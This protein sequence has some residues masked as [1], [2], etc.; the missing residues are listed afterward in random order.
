[1]TDPSPTSQPTRRDLLAGAAASTLL[2]LHAEAEA[3]P[4]LPQNPLQAQVDALRARWAQGTEDLQGTLMLNRESE[5]GSAGQT[6]A[7]RRGFA[8]IEIFK[9]I[10]RLPVEAQAQRP[11][12]GLFAEVLTAVGHASRAAAE[13]ARGYAGAVGP[14]QDPDERHLHG[15]VGALRIGLRDAKT[16]YGRQQMLDATLAEVQADKEPGAL[17]AKLRRD[18]RRFDR[19]ESL[20][21]RIAADFNATSVITSEDPALVARVQAA[22]DA[23]EGPPPSEE[24]NAGDR[25][26]MVLG[27][28]A[29]GVVMVLGIFVATVLA[30]VFSC[31]GG[32]GAGIPL[33]LLGICIAW[34]G[35][36]GMTQI[37]D[38]LRAYDKAHPQYEDD[39]EDSDAAQARPRRAPEDERRVELE[40]AGW[41]EAEARVGWSATGLVA[42][43][44]RPVVARAWGVV[45]GGRLWAADADGDG[46]AAGKGAPLPG[47]P[48]RAL[49]G[50]VG[51][52]VFFIGAEARLPAG[53]S[54]PL[55]LACNV[56]P[57]ERQALRGG[58]SVELLQARG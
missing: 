56:A 34:L 23:S 26:A 20:A 10:E 27:I 16:T 15:A 28:L 6:E 47:A 52:R 14:D 38:R 32:S 19:A 48:A 25:A 7:L 45:R 24:G 17:R 35:H 39:G 29:M 58:F 18:L 5:R 43:S 9:E 3:G 1:M 13:L 53:L 12:Q 49:I 37:R 8:A 51:E 42:L 31:A 50:R 22:M 41:A 30:C 36:W 2:A 54:G 40:S 55:E 57:E 44:D 21:A 46:V 4:A 33:L 11:M